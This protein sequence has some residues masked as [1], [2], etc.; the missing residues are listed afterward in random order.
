MGRQLARQSFNL[1]CILTPQQFDAVDWHHISLT[2]NA[3]PKLF[4]LWVAKHIIC[5]AGTMSYLWH[6]TGEFSFCPC[7]N[8]M[9]ETTAHI[10]RCQDPG[11]QQALNLSIELLDTWLANSHT[12]PALQTAVVEYLGHRGNPPWATISQGFPL[13]YRKLGVEQDKIGWDG[14]TMGMISSEFQHIQADHLTVSP[15]RLSLEQWM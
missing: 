6:Q 5:V 10:T 9:Q 14:F 2:L 12:N 7:C 8:A 4:Q 3:L 15:T 1:K 11:R 13:R